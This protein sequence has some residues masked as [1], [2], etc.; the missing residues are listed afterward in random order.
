ML[1][2]HDRMSGGRTRRKG[3]QRGCLRP[4]PRALQLAAP[5]SGEGVRVTVVRVGGVVALAAAAE[6][7][8][9]DAQALH[10][11]VPCKRGDLKQISCLINFTLF[12]RL[13]RLVHGSL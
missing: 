12:T 11:C 10:E 5:E 7:A 13:I 3:R 9:A 2:A 6:V 1:A 8:E 4:L